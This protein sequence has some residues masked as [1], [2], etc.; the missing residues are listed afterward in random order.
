M[1]LRPH[2][3]SLLLV[4]PLVTLFDGCKSDD[5]DDPHASHPVI[6]SFTPTSGIRSDEVVITGEN[7]SSSKDLN[8]VKFNG[9]AAGIL[10][11][12]ETELTVVV[13]DLATTGPITVE[14]SGMEATS[15]TD[16]IVPVP[17]V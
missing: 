1:K 16:F 5:D 3:M 14:V 10:D 12:S 11:A 7:F 13:P 6:V 4:V 2:F 17:V 9:V 15:D 8:I